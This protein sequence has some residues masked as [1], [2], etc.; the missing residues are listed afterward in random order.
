MAAIN[1]L[2]L[3]AHPPYSGSKPGKW[4]IAF[5]EMLFHIC[6]PRKDSLI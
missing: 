5:A 6:F 2:I 1:G 3:K 4:V